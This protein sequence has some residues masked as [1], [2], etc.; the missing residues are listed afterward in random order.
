MD[1]APERIFQ[2]STGLGVF[3]IMVQLCRAAYQSWRDTMRDLREENER[4]RRE[5]LHLRRER[6]QEDG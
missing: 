5:N 3:V 2:I 4:L 1:D 6:F